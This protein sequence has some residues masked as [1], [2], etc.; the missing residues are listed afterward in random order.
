MDAAQTAFTLAKEVS[1]QLITLSTGILAVTITFA[2]DSSAGRS[3]RHVA[4]L[5]YGWAIYL[6]SILC[7]I[8][9][10]MALTGT[11]MPADGAPPDKPT[12]GDNVRFPAGLQIVTFVAA[13]LLVVAYG[14]KTIRPSE[15]VE[16]H[17]KP[18]DGHRI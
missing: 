5:R 4:W 10:L 14:W 15:P 8:W 9:T 12:F 3:G 17:G 13:T 16:P 18:T 2:K 7:G 6:L 1:V 11:L